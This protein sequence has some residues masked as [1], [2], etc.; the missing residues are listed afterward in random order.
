MGRDIL[1]IDTSFAA[2]F[3]PETL[4]LNDLEAVR[5]L[6]S[7]T[8][9]IDWHKLDLDTIDKVDVFLRNS[10]FDPEDPQDMERIRFVFHQ[11]INY[12]EEHHEVRFP[13]EVRNPADVRNVFIT[14][15]TWTGRFR[16][17]QMLACMVLKLMHTINHMEA[18][19]LKHRLPIS[20]AELFDRAEQAIIKHADALRRDGYPLMAFYGSRKTRTS[21]ISKLL[22][23]RESIAAT[24]FDKLRFRIVVRE[25]SELIP[26]LAHLTRTL[27]PVNY[28]IPG[29]SHNNLVDFWQELEREQHYAKLGETLQRLSNKERVTKPG[30]ENPFSATGYKSVNWIVDFPV[31]VDDVLSKLDIDA[32]YMLGRV[33]YVMVEFQLLDSETETRNESGANAHEHYKAR[34]KKQVESRLLK[35]GLR[36]R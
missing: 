21:V 36:R 27:F 1:D 26:V 28:I 13:D 29:E 25:P 5:L 14:A 33:V 32:G 2:K 22:S 6:L 20:E 30:P 23:K 34:Q 4:D 10:L 3:L 7:G 11:A 12:L 15:S 8:S 24:I 17:S 9:V 35:G 31:R 16:R 18:A 19:D